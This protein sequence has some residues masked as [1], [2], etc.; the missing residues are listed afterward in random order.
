VHEQQIVFTLAEA[1][2]TDLGLGPIL[3]KRQTI[4][5]KSEAMHKF[6]KIIAMKVFFLKESCQQ[7]PT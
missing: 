2:E 1:A 3:R 6:W 5:K 7:L 4:Y